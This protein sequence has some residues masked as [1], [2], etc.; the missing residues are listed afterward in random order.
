MPFNAQRQLVELD[1]FLAAL[2]LNGVPVSPAD[3][4]RLRRLFALEPQLDRHGLQTM[5][6]ALLVRT[7]TQRER[8]EA[9]FAE[10]CPDHDADWPEDEETERG[11]GSEQPTIL[12]RRPPP[13]IPSFED[14]AETQSH[15]MHPNLRWLP[16][17]VGIVLLGVL[18]AWWWWPRPIQPPV[19]EPKLRPVFVPPIS[20]ESD[21]DA[22]PATPVDTVWFWKADVDTDAIRVPWRLGPMECVL[23]GLAALATAGAGW[24][25]YRQRFPDLT[26]KQQEYVGYG[27]RPLP[28]LARDDGALIDARDRRQLVW[29]IEHFVSDDP[30]RRLD[31]RQTVDAT[32][33]AGGYVQLHFKPAVYDR[34][35]W[36]WLDR[37]LDRTTPRTAV[38]QLTATLAAAG[39]DAHQG[40]FTDVPGRVDWPEQ[41]GYRP[42]YEEGHGRQ[43][44]VAIFS[45]GEGLAHR[46][47]N[48]L[49]RPATARLLR[50]LRRWPRLC[51][52]DC[53]P[54]GARLAPLLVPFGLDVIALHEVPHWLGG[55]EVGPSSASP[56]GAALHGEARVWA[57]AVALGRA[58]ADT[59]SAQSLR[60]ALR[61]RASPW[62][63]DQML[64]E[65]NTAGN[66]MRHINWLLRCEPL[67]VNNVPQPGS[68]ARRALRWWWRRYAE[69]AKSNQA[70]ENP[71]LPWQHSLASRR[72]ELEQ[73]LLQLYLDP[74]SAARRLAQLADEELADDVRERLALFAAADHRRSDGGNDAAGIFLTWRF[75]DL[76][77]FTRHTLRRL[78]FADTFLK[79]YALTSFKDSPRLVLAITVLAML[80][81][82]A[83]GTAT[84]RWLV[85]EPPRVVTDNPAVY[86]HPAFRAQTVRVIEP[87]LGETYRVVLGSA[88]QSV[89][90][91]KVPE[92]AEL[93][94]MWTWHAENNGTEIQGS[95]TVL[96]RAGR[97]AQ[98]IRPCSDNWPQRSI[99]VIAAAY[100]DDVKARQLAIRLLDTGSADQVL[101]GTDWQQSLVQ[102]L[103][104]SPALNQDTQV[105][106]VLQDAADAE[107]A[108][109][110]LA[111]HPG[112]WA[113][114]SSGNF[115][116]LA[117]AVKFAGS[118]TLD[119]MPSELREQLRVHH[120]QGDVRLVGGPEKPQT[121]STGI[122][123]VRICPGTFTMGTVKQDGARAM[124]MAREE[125]K[126]SPPR[127]VIL[128]AFDMA[129]T[130]TTEAQYV[131]IDPEQGKKYGKGTNVPVVNVTWE[132]AQTICQ[133]TKG[134][135]PTEAQWEYA[136][137]GGSRFP[138]SFGDD[139]AL[140]KHYAWYSGNAKGVQEVG[141]RRQ[142]PLGLYDMHGNVWEWAQD[143]YNEKYVP[144]V[145]VDPSGPSSGKCSEEYIQAVKS[146][147]L[148]ID[149]SEGCRVV[150]GGSFVF[151]PDFLRSA[152]RFFD[153]L[154]E[155][156]LWNLGFR[157]ARV[158]QDLSR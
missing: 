28:P 81:L 7:P 145:V 11:R 43:A 101:V 74:V 24:W 2:R 31:L 90:L 103:G 71:L 125:E 66:H 85:P 107:R 21:P 124:A 50:D 144:G 108:A 68:L 46:L 94:V 150:R 137:R 106:V 34:E 61:L 52:V 59:A 55:V 98:P 42:V 72:W 117:R 100:K 143:W 138:W 41:H 156:R 56:L 78:G 123:W 45:D 131:K 4:D 109:T 22:P 140:L 97:L 110:Q 133:K 118:Q 126:I 67:G 38:H 63:V 96:L 16:A 141:Q 129:A 57:A 3:I 37:Q 93:P 62:L 51:F 113:V 29:N 47:N 120:K 135:L 127:T 104:S 79:K 84:Y 9:L 58:Q 157:C 88:R 10:W 114:V 121:D 30:T 115:A 14:I 154:P 18:L 122:A 64:T 105:L 80:A 77:A 146:L 12:G 76:P 69:A 153:F 54:S 148:K 139:E 35:I 92:G 60:V 39:L 26:P 20:D 152:I 75:D 130:E 83:F 13:E 149:T 134:N 128:S 82:S 53:S 48:P 91:P 17:V 5:L 65:A 25:R 151:S 111:G 19:S 8:F 136:A 15:P 32:A 116:K 99:V 86:D 95:N 23:L 33:K 132:E 36:F 44:L 27:W 158:P 1:D 73:A 89:V 40:W 119:A 87:T 49:Y 6:S 155:F 70:Q 112:P 102:R 147:N 142:N